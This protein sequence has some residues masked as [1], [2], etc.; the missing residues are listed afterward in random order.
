MFLEY[1][2]TYTGRSR[3]ICISLISDIRFDDLLSFRNRG[4][5][6]LDDHL[7]IIWGQGVST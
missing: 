5:S 7:V 3:A 4:M 6:N 2:G 1:P